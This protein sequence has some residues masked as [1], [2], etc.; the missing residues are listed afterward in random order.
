M[1]YKYLLYVKQM[2]AC[3]IASCMRT[4]TVIDQ[5]TQFLSS[6]Q[7]FLSMSSRIVLIVKLHFK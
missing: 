2:F 7:Q 3:G 1:E 5:N 4:F 6:F